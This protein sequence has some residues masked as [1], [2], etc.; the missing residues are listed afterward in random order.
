MARQGPF[1]TPPPGFHLNSNERHKSTAKDASPHVITQGCTDLRYWDPT[2]EPIRL[3]DAIF[4]GESL[5]EW[6]YC[7]AKI[8]YISDDVAHKLNMARDLRDMLCSFSKNMRRCH[9]TI[10][11]IESCDGREGI[12]DMIDSGEEM[13]KFLQDFLKK[14][15]YKLLCGDGPADQFL[16]AL[17]GYSYA[18][19][20]CY[21]ETEKQIEDL[22]AWNELLEKCEHILQDPKHN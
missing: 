17:F 5:S 1:S 19:E 16:E 13:L 4:D 20:F 8:R 11:E 22:R 7:W 14:R 21:T 10:P 9:V 12:A 2:Q 3:L 18:S 6:I 15:E